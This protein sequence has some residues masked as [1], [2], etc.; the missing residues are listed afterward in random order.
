MTSSE[1]GSKLRCGRSGETKKRH[2]PKYLPDF[3]TLSEE[4]IGE[5]TV[6]FTRSIVNIAY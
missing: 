2:L 5:L 1:T 4:N 6:G 3:S